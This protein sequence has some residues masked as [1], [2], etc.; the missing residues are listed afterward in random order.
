MNI[1]FK[2]HAR[3][4]S[5]ILNLQPAEITITV[6][7]PAFGQ[8]ST[9]NKTVSPTINWVPGSTTD[10]SVDVS[11]DLPGSYFGTILKFTIAVANNDLLICGY[12]HHG[13][14]QIISNPLWDGE[15]GPY[16]IT[17]HTGGGGTMGTGSLPILDGQTVT[18]DANWSFVPFEPTAG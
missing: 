6:E 18:F 3:K 1:T 16:D 4:T 13:S 2:C 11:I 14:F 10:D 17:G 7:N 5:K 12:S 15:R 8:V 9:Y